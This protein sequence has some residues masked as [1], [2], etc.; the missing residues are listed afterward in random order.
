MPFTC[1]LMLCIVQSLKG[2]V[3][4]FFN[5]ILKDFNKIFR[6]TSIAL[7]GYFGLR[8]TTCK[9]EAKT[10]EEIICKKTKWTKLK[11]LVQPSGCKQSVMSQLVR[12]Q[13]VSSWICSWLLF[14]VA[15]EAVFG[16]TAL[17]SKIRS[18]LLVLCSNIAWRLFD[19]GAVSWEMQICH[20]KGK[21]CPTEVGLFT[22]LAQH[23][24]YSLQWFFYIPYQVYF[25]LYC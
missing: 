7:T 1:G 8:F 23:Q 11:K 19:E 12:K 16:K 2:M 14:L 21:S 3:N 10:E 9:R 15:C 17:Y 18:F 4:N 24:K 13:K 5:K 25:S 22:A 20:N 6:I